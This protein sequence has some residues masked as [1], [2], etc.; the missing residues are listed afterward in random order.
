MKDVMRDTL[1]AQLASNLSFLEKSLHSLY[2]YLH[3]HVINFTSS[4][5]IK[6]VEGADDYSVFL[7]DECIYQQYY[8]SQ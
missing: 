8:A 6:R 2:Q 4:V 7:G 1:E 5:R 3:P